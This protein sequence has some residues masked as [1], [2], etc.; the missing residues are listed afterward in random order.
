MMAENCSN[1]RELAWPPQLASSVRISQR[2]RKGDL[3]AWKTLWCRYSAAERWGRGIPWLQTAHPWAASWDSHHFGACLGMDQ[4]TTTGTCGLSR[5]L[6]IRCL[7]GEMQR[8]SWF[9]ST[10]FF[11]TRKGSQVQPLS[12]PPYPI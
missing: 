5:T 12:R 6:R 9:P 2:A 10:G 1:G 3:L 8:A 11:L 7:R 4:R